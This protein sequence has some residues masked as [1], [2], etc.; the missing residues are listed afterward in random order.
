MFL[1]DIVTTYL[2]GS[3]D[4][5]IHMKILEGFKMPEVFMINPR[6]FILLNYINLYMC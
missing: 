4:K 3:I 5:D 6:V 1:I 2:Y